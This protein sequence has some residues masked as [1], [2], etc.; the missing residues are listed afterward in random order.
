[1]IKRKEA[2]DKID[3]GPVGIIL[4]LQIIIFSY[5]PSFRQIYVWISSP[6]NAPCIVLKLRRY[7]RLGRISVQTPLVARL[8]FETQRGCE[9]FGHLWVELVSN[10]VINI[11]L[12]G[13][14]H[15][16]WPKVCRAEFFSGFIEVVVWKTDDYLPD[17]VSHPN[18]HVV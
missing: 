16:Q 4:Q 7:I 9:A 15:R 17:D 10:A 5:M 1:M 13:L 6:Q 18:L 3:N 11:G 12:V 14:P 2:I 8:G